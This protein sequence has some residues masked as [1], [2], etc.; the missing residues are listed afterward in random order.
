M[1]GGCTYQ[2]KYITEVACDGLVGLFFG[3]RLDQVG[4]ILFFRQQRIFTTPRNPC[5]LLISRQF[6]GGAIRT[7]FD[8]LGS[9]AS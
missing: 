1:S 6:T 2:D 7:L 5:V 3:W 9:Q 4:R 8:L